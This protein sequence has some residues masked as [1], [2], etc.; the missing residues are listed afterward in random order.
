MKRGRPNIRRLIQPKILEILSKTSIPLNISSLRK[1]LSLEINKPVNWNTLKK[2]VDEL[3][4]LEKV[5]PIYLPHSKKP[6]EKGLTL[7]TIKK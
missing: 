7:Y 5:E 2:Y 4:K 6:G 1:Q 3:V